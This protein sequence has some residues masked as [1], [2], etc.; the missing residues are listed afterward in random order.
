MIGSIRGIILTKEPPYLLLDVNGIG[1]ELSLPMTSFYQLPDL[2]QEVVLHTH[3]VIREDAHQLYGFYQERDRRLFRELIKVNGI[4]PKLALTIL[5]GIEL[6]ELILC[7]KQNNPLPLT[8]VPG[9]GKKTAER[10][11]IEMK[12]FLIKW[13]MDAESYKEPTI[14]NPSEDAIEA[15]IALGYKPKQAQDAIATVNTENASIETLI[16]SA[17]RQMSV[18]K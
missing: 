3:L 6:P 10:L 9:I 4:G 18:G 7:A 2:K 11:L 5:S 1:Y 13:T 17:L 12:E 8:K 14:K 16:R 15:L